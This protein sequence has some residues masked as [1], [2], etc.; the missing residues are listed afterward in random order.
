MNITPRQRQVLQ[1]LVRGFGNAEIAEEL[2]ISTGTVKQ[3]VRA[4]FRWSE[5]RGGDRRVK[6]VIAVMAQPITRTLL[7][8][9]QTEDD[10]PR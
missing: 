4:L 7:E 6:L 10:R 5:I 9:D 3:H 1:L 8:K 2:N